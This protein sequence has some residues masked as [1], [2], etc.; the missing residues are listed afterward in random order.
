MS[1]HYARARDESPADDRA[2]LCR[3]RSPSP[4]TSPR[5]EA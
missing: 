2:D 5:E 4:V 1:D 3:L